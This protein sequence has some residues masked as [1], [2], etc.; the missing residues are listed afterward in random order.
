M[1]IA[2][3][4]GSGFIGSNLVQ[5]LV[6]QGHDVRVLSR[7]DNSQKEVENFQ[8]NLCD[9][10]SRAKLEAFLDGVDILFHCAGQVTDEAL[11]SSLHVDGT[12]RLVEAAEGRVGRWVQLSS[13]GA[14]GVF[15]DGVITEASPEAPIGIYETT[16]TQ[17]DEIVRN[18][19]LPF[20]ILRPSNVFGNTMN[21]QSLFQL[22]RAIR[23]GLFF[24]I[25]KKGSIVN[26]IHVDDV[27]SALIT[28]GFHPKAPGNVYN[29]SQ[30]IDIEHMAQAFLNGLGV[31]RTLFRLPEIPLRV[32][33][34]LVGWFPRFPLSLSR[35]DAMTSKCKYGSEK[36]V[37]ELEFNFEFS[38]EERFL[39]FSRS[40]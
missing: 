25:G 5:A 4:G 35:I 32:M 29:L 21:N 16:K 20:V 39:Q 3:S 26:Y 14:Y 2:V 28:C 17:S 7:Y 9:P 10:S 15:R 34:F 30:N 33:A 12:Q 36:I 11:M 8:A 19:G 13:V 23:Q 6:L 18:S 24:L 37:R 22:V 40:V 31:E 38:L 1:K 27:V